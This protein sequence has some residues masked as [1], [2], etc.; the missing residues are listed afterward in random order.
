MRHW[1]KLCKLP[2]ARLLKRV[3]LHNQA[4]A[5]KQ[6]GL[7]N[8]IVKALLENANLHIWE[9]KNSDAVSIRHVTKAIYEAEM[10]RYQG[11]MNKMTCQE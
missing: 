3:F 1:H 2:Y 8:N 6:R 9:N 10:K 11:E 7:T 5:H 4:L